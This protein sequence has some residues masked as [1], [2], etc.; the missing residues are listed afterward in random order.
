MAGNYKKI[1][2]IVIIIAGIGLAYFI[3]NGV[4]PPIKSSGLDSGNKTE[5]EDKNSQLFTGGNAFESQQEND[6]GNQQ[7][8]LTE[9]FGQSILDNVKNGNFLGTNGQQISESALVSGSSF[10]DLLNSEKSQFNF[11]STVSDSDII[12]S[13]DLSSGA[14]KKY[15]TD[16]G[17]ASKKD[18]GSFNKT[19]LGVIFDTYKDADMSS[20]SQLADIYKKLAE[21]Y[22]KI[23][24]PQDWADVHKKAIVNFINSEILYKAMSEYATDPLKGYFALDMVDAL[25]KN[26][27][28]VQD[29]LIQKAGSIH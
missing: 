12:I 8:N 14:K 5:G 10:S 29:L 2:A 16:I 21:D 11:V 26:S 4:I 28:E 22:K 25:V 7:N 1:F 9:N 20:A 24:V 15:L 18:F 27:N 6:V 23:P 19:Y 17:E 13:K 3:I